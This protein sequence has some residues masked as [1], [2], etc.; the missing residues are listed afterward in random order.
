MHGPMY[1]K[2]KA[3]ILLSQDDIMHCVKWLQKDL[4]YCMHRIP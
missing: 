1:T 3:L 2:C 4:S